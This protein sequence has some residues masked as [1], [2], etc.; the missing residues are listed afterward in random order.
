MIDTIPP[1]MR[2]L[3]PLSLAV[4]LLA[5]AGLAAGCGNQVAV[6][7]VASTE[8]P[9]LDIDDL[10][11][12]VQLSRYLNPADVEDQTYLT[13][14]P[15]NSPPPAGDETYFAVFMR[16]TNSTEEAISPAN[17]FEILDT[18]GNVY[19][20]IPLDAKVNPFAYVAD[21]IPPKS[22]IPPEDSIASEGVIKQGALLLFKLKTDSLQNR[23]LQLRFRKGS[24]TQ[25]TIDLDV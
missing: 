17:D 19:R 2:R 10:Q 12:Q 11:Y 4:A 8:G 24:G 5:F 7:T 23:P 6:R 1:R 25:G 21:P 20:P 13:G 22:M 15:P 16:V 18:Q 14:L 9:Y 3:L